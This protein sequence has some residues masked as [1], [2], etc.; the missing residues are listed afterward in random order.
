MSVPASSSSALQPQVS[1]TVTTNRQHGSLP[2]EWVPPVAATSRVTFADLNSQPLCEKGVA[3]R[4]LDHL[5][6]GAHARQLAAVG[7]CDRLLHHRGASRWQIPPRDHLASELP[8]LLGLHPELGHYLHLLVC[9]AP[10]P[11]TP[12]NANTPAHRIVLFILQLGYI[13]HLFSSKAESVNAACAVGSR[14]SI[15]L[16]S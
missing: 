9:A 2:P 10:R 5:V 16:S 7:G 15:P 13:S 4:E 8:V 14:T 1:S 12:P 11:S 3:Q 6:Q